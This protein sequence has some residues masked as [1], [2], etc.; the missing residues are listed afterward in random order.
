M[1]N[2]T[3]GFDKDG[4]WVLISSVE[5]EDT[6]SLEEL[7]IAVNLKV[8]EESQANIF[9]GF[10]FDSLTFSMSLTA[11]INW[12]NLNFI[13]QAMFPLTIMSK[14]DKEYSLSLANRPA[15]YG[16]AL[17]HKNSCLQNGNAKKKQVNACEK[18]EDLKS[19][20]DGWGFS[21]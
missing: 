12:S 3:Y 11:Q 7:K 5:V 14:D 1:I 19:L 10:V 13:P 18:I 15:F 9:K 21:Y 2:E 4:K 6:R 17:V 8:D 20:A 16:A